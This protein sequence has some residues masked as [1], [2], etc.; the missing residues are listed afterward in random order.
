MT[1]HPLVFPFLRENLP[2]GGPKLT[3]KAWWGFVT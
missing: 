3:Q 2:A 1:P